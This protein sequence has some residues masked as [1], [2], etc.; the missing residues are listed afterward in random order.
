MKKI[1]AIVVNWNGKD[2]L[3]DCL[4]SLS[5]QDYQNLE[6]IVSDNGSEDGSIEAIKQD[7]PQVLLLE[8]GKNLGFGPAVNKGLEIASGD[9][10]I[11]LNNDLYLKANSLR[12]LANMLDAKHD[13][14]AAIPKI[15]YYEKRNIINSFGVLV[16]YTSICCPHLVDQ[17]D[18]K[19]LESLET[20]CGG[21]FM[22]RREI[23][24]SVGSFDPDLFLYHEDHDLSWRI[25]LYGWKL[26]TNP[27]AEIYHHYHFNKGVF[28][29]Y[30]SEKNRLYLLLKNLELKT[31]FLI[32]PALLLIEIAQLAHAIGNGWFFLKLKSYAEIMDVLYR[33]LVKRRKLQRSRKVPDREIFRL[34]EGKLKISGIQSNLL[35][36]ILNPLLNSYWKIIRKWI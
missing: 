14:G 22:F 16:H 5:N 20:A 2:V 9:Y 6:I 29:Y 31:L 35:D 36:L 3:L 11:F 4:E 33:I 23:Y 30:S 28:K 32:S 12:E 18:P 24:E 21:I 10:F 15:L 27:K 8:N 34:H 13:T 17:T 7:Y 26:R 19:N 1:S 25:R